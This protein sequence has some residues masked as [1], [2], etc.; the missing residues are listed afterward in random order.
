MDYGMRMI[1]FDVVEY[2]YDPNKKRGKIVK[3]RVKIH[4]FLG[5]KKSAKTNG[6]IL[7]L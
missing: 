1:L 7:S 4:L 3:S 2:S 5:K 6:D